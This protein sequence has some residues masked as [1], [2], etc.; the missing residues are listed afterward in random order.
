MGST[1]LSFM[2]QFS[3]GVSGQQVA[4]PHR[5]TEEPRFLWI[6]WFYLP[7]GS[8]HHLL[9]TIRK[10]NE[11]DTIFQHVEGRAIPIF[12]YIP[13]LKTS[14]IA[15]VGCKKFCKMYFLLDICCPAEIPYIFGGWLAISVKFFSVTYFL[16]NKLHF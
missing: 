4:F 1:Y 15:A 13:L 7:L 16:N 3:M 6:S 14:H 9:L 12:S 8:Q 11:M 10:G 5:V 2:Y